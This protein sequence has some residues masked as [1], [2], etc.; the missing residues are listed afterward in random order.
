M[1]AL[2]IAPPPA[3]RL[4]A[5]GSGSGWFATPFPYGSFIR[6]TLPVYWRFP[7]L[8]SRWLAGPWRGAELHLLDECGFA[9][10][11]Q[12]KGA[13][14][15]FQERWPELVARADRRQRARLPRRRGR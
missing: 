1:R 11:T 15:R 13:R 7:R 10:R 5:Y 14:G 12:E 8:D 2:A 4:T 9:R 3:S 6:S